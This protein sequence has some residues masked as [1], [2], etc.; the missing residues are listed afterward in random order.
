MDGVPIFLI[1]SS[2]GV[3][4]VIRRGK[5]GDGVYRSYKI[6]KRLESIDRAYSGLLDT[7]FDLEKIDKDF[8]I[9][10]L[11]GQPPGKVD[12]TINDVVVKPP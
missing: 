11:D 1:V 10:P 5:I 2:G 8:D 7:S 12:Q 9:G 4:M 6:G 3:F